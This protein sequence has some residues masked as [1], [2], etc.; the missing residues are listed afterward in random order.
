MVKQIPRGTTN[1]PWSEF[2]D[3]VQD[4][5]GEK[6]A[7]G[8]TWEAYFEPESQK[9]AEPEEDA[10]LLRNAMANSEI[11]PAQATEE[12]EEKIKKQH[13]F[14]RKTRWKEWKNPKNRGKA[15]RTRKSS[16]KPAER[17]R[18]DPRPGQHFE[19]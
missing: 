18:T 17:G 1:M 15:R 11:A 16:G 7:G 6:A 13:L 8:R 14:Q 3:I 19:P 4:L 5:F 10:P 9:T 2:F 12:K